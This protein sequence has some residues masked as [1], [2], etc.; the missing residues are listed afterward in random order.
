VLI[1]SVDLVYL[2]LYCVYFKDIIEETCLILNNLQAHQTLIM[3]GY[4]FI[5]SYHIIL[6]VFSLPK[7]KIITFFLVHLAV[8]QSFLTLNLK[9]QNKNSFYDVYFVTELIKYC[10]LG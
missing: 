5:F 9:T 8:T 3:Q 10:V 4:K 1:L 6:R 2:L 7:K